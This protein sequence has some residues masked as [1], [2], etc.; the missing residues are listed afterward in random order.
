MGQGILIT[1]EVEQLRDSVRLLERG[2]DVNVAVSAP[3]REILVLKFAKADDLGDGFSVCP[4]LDRQLIALLLLEHD[5][6]A[7]TLTTNEVLSFLTSY[8]H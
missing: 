7:L 6:V 4:F 1:I 5:E 8:L 3:G 2:V